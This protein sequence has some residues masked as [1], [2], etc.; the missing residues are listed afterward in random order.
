MWRRLCRSEPVI[1]ALAGA[2]A[3]VLALLVASNALGLTSLDGSA[4]AA[5]SAAVVAISGFVAA[6]V[7]AAVV[8]VPTHQAAVDEALHT[9]VPADAIAWGGD[10]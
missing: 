7:R 8:P 10:V 9:P 1:M 3:V 4:L 2:D 6:V 5:I